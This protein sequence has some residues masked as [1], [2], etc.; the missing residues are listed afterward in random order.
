[1]LS[2]SRAV[3]GSA[4]EG[5]RVLT[6]FEEPEVAWLAGT[7]FRAAP[8]AL[9]TIDAQGTQQAAQGRCADLA[10]E[11]T[12]RRVRAPEHGIDAPRSILPLLRQECIFYHDLVAT[13]KT[14]VHEHVPVAGGRR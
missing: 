9:Q 11:L 14:A 5:G 12:A 6:H 8:E 1:M 13:L 4:Q 3:S 2:I 7:A 10:G